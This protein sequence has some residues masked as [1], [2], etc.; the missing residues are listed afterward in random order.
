MQSNENQIF[1]LE[2]YIDS[3]SNDNQYS[4]LLKEC[5]SLQ[6]QINDELLKKYK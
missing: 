6:Q 4:G 5:V 1:S 3:K 2:N